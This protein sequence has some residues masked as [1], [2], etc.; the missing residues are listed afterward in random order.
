M[1]GVCVCMYVLTY[2]CIMFV[3]MYVR[4]YVCC[5]CVY[6]CMYVCMY[7]CACVR[8]CMYVYVCVRVCTYVRMYYVCTNADSPVYFYTIIFESLDNSDTEI[9]RNMGIFLPDCTASHSINIQVHGQSIFHLAVLLLCMSRQHHNKLY[10][11]L[12]RFFSHIVRSLHLNVPNIDH[13]CVCAIL[14]WP[15]CAAITT[16]FGHTQ[17]YVLNYF[18]IFNVSPCI[19]QFNNW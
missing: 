4:M 18:I 14:L 8:V 3:C 12:R 11:F 9:L 17:Q 1:V 16:S 15:L 13:C 5:V 7:M 2:V 6:V 19:F 10:V